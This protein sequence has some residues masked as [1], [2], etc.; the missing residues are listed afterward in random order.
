MMDISN[1]LVWTF[2]RVLKVTNRNCFT[3]FRLFFS[4]QLEC[5]GDVESEMDVAVGKIALRFCDESAFCQASRVREYKLEDV[6][7]C[8][9]IHAE[10]ERVEVRIFLRIIQPVIVLTGQ[11][12]TLG[13]LQSPASANG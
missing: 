7:S 5:T 10:T 9:N 13:D 2:Q 6:T 11:R 1:K 3:S 4:L 8:L 12:N